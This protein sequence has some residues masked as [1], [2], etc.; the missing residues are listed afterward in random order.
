MAF[1]L[2][3]Q[4]ERW[5]TKDHY[6]PERATKPRDGLAD[7]SAAQ[8]MIDAGYDWQES[9]VLLGKLH[10]AIEPYA[11]D[12]PFAIKHGL[13]EKSDVP[14]FG[15]S[16]KNIQQKLSYMTHRGEHDSA[17]VTFSY[18]PIPDEVLLCLENATHVGYLAQ[19]LPA[20][21][22]ELSVEDKAHILG[23]HMPPQWDGETPVY[24]ARNKDF[25]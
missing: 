3:Y 21:F 2:G 10:K 23:T 13:I 25:L 20:D 7:I 14:N 19:Q 16:I 18:Q 24:T 11:N 4:A 22:K 9:I 8:R 6:K 12:I 15:A 17:E 1:A 5:F